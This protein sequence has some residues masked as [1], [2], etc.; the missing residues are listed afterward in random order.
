MI[1]IFFDIDGT[2]INTAGAGGHAMVDTLSEQTGLSFDVGSVSFAGRTDRSLVTEFLSQHDVATTDEVF[3]AFQEAFVVR[4]ATTLHERNGEVLPGA[5]DVLEILES[6]DHVRLGIITGNLREAAR[7]KLEHF[8]LSKFFYSGGDPIG[9]FGDV[10]VERNDVA[11]SALKALEASVGGAS[12]SQPWVVGDTVSDIKCGKAINARVLAVET[13]SF[14]REQ[15]LPH[16][17]ELVLSDLT[18]ADAWVESI[19][20]A[21]P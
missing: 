20:S 17:P 14:R 7:I 19:R 1:T 12:S 5:F 6:C 9:G 11:R 13:G 8:K 18:H 4:L 16:G 3:H 10:H 21:T 15:L 2:L